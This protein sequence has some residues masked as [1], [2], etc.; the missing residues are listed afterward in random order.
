MSDDRRTN[1]QPVMDP[2]CVGCGADITDAD[3]FDLTGVHLEPGWTFTQ[4]SRGYVRVRCPICGGGLES[5]E[6]E[7]DPWQWVR[8]DW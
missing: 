4:N 2:L 8:G 1:R 3:N 5:D 7:L 6:Q